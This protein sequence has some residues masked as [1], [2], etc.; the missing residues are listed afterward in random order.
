MTDYSEFRIRIERGSSKRSYRVYASGLGGE[1]QGVFKVPFPEADLENFVL[2]VGRTRR[3]VRR[4]ESPEWGQAKV[5]GGKLFSAIVQGP[6]GDLY[7]A[8]LSTAEADGQGLRIT[9]SLTDVPELG[10]I[11]W[12]Y[13][14]DKPNFLSISSST[15][16]VRYLDLPRP[17][18]ALETQLPLRILAVVSAPIGVEQLD[19]PLERKNLDKALK[20]LVDAN[21][22]TIEWL[23]QPTLLALTKKL[24]SD[25][26]HILH[27]IGHGGFDESN[28][29]G[30]LLFENESHQGEIVSGEQLAIVLNNKK[31]LRLVFLNSCEGARNSSKDPFSGVAASL[32]QREI[33]A[34]IAMQFEITDRA[35][36]IFA[37]E[38]YS[39]LAE[40]QPIDAAIT[41]A[42]LAIFADHNDVEW[43]TPV[44]FMRVADGRLFDLADAATDLPRIP[45]E[46][47]PPRGGAEG[48][49][50]GE[51]IRTLLQ[52][53]R[54]R[55]VA[56]VVGVV[57][58]LLI[59]VRLLFPP[60]SGGS[61]TVST[62][63][64]FQ[65]HLVGVGGSGF[66]PGENV[67]LSLDGTPVATVLVDAAGAIPP[68]DLDVGDRT[69][70]RVTAKGSVSGTE[71]N[72]NFEFTPGA[73]ETPGVTDS[74][75]PT[76]S[77]APTPTGPAT[78]VSPGILFYSDN[79]QESGE[80]D[81][82]LYLLDPVTG[83]ET[84]LTHNTVDDIF[85][86]WS[87][88]Y[89]QIAFSRGGDIFISAFSDGE[90]Q[91]NPTRMTSG[92]ANDFF[93]A[94]SMEGQIAFV[95]TVGDGSAIMSVPADQ[96]G[97]TPFEIVNGPQ[98][99]APAWSPDGATLAF[100]SIDDKGV[101]TI[102]TIGADGTGGDPVIS[103]GFSDLNANWSPDGGT[104]VFVRRPEGG[105]RATSEIH[106]VELATKT[107]SDPLTDNEV[108]DG[109]PVWS[110]DGTQIAFYRALDATDKPDFHLWVMDAN[111]SN[112]TDLMPSREGRNLDPIW[113]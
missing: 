109:N 25:K 22:V 17:R 47:L 41:E 65:T 102:Y 96:P 75:T 98:V 19:A 26:Y 99:R 86:T 103:D 74:P 45:K 10:E 112:P 68:T 70:G 90:L 87:P 52:R 32:V 21:A 104:I 110:P 13:L 59:G 48:L 12:E 93:P 85:P 66:T 113:R 2:K 106:T 40:G 51:R 46:S 9:L 28:G 49:T 7:R 77:E 16:V 42:R 3:G 6:V 11:P 67:D 76:E 58:A 20:P 30:A 111:G 88:D 61:L 79:D 95:R 72:T 29:E 5:F 15:P 81:N 82:E 60:S 1:V 36:V 8:A 89:T 55:K 105:N 56:V 101:S 50:R 14:Y 62:A 97:E 92:S 33:P 39:M 27:F 73:S 100:N 24:R 18:R 31:A 64:S 4:I 23:E 84:Q 34:V 83:D 78:A 35:A 57:A 108:Q 44:L 91:G 80:T 43:G 54:W 37:S 107:V 71:V 38:F 63:G 53:V 69:K 94:W